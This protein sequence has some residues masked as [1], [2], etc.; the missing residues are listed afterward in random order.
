[1]GPIHARVPTRCSQII[2][3]LRIRGFA[4]TLVRSPYGYFYFTGGET[5][6]WPRHCVFVCSIRQLTFGQWLAEYEALKA[7][8][9][10]RG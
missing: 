9:R 3:Q 5:G 6:S 7:N 10:G 8:A 1:M 4:E 2:K